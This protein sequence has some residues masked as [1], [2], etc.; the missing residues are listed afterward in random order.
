MITGTTHSVEYTSTGSETEFAY[1]W[2]ILDKSH[3]LVR[4]ISSDGET[5]ETLTEGTDYTVSGVRLGS[6]NVTL[7]GD[8]LASGTIIRIERSVSAV[9][10]TDMRNWG[11]FYPE[12]LEDALDYL[13]MVIQGAFD[14]QAPPVYTTATRPVASEV[15]GGKAIRVKDT[16]E[17]EVVQRCLRSSSGVWG[18]VVTETGP[19]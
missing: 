4:T 12:T 7:V 6:G 3:L 5:V 19:V 15:W 17:T 1:S 18:W 10:S 9:Q 16:D 11:T 13:C 2:L 14:A 8:P